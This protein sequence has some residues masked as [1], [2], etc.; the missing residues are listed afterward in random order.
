MRHLFGLGA[1]LPALLVFL[2]VCTPARPTSGTLVGRILTELGLPAAG[3]SVSTRPATASA[4]TDSVGRFVLNYLPAGDYRLLAAKPGFLSDSL[5]FCIRAGETTQIAET[6]RTV[7]RTVAAE[8]LTTICS[9]SDECRSSIYALKDSL[10]DRLLHVEY[11]ATD[12][13]LAEW[14]E[15]FITDAGEQRR[16]Y[17]APDFHLGGWLYLDGRTEQRTTGAYRRLIDSLLLVPAAAHLNL[18]GTKSDSE[19]QIALDLHAVEALGPDC[20]VGLGI[21]EAGPIAYDRG[22]GDSVYFRNV[23]VDFCFAETLSLEAGASATV[24][25]TIAIPDTLSP[26]LLPFHVVNKN[27]LGIFAIIQDLNTKQVIQAVQKRL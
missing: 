20:G 15:P 8:M 12:D 25:R 26:R 5:L 18:S 2:L 19:V 24:E 22:T 23:L 3:A 17:Y 11:H 16:R 1:I 9:C 4:L 13:T 27:D 21:Y 14:W 6:L 10:G 7:V